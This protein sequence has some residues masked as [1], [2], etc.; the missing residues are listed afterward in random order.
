MDS[1]WMMR[2]ICSAE[3]SVSRMWP[4]PPQRGQGWGAFAQGGLQALAAHFHQAELADGA[5]LHAGA[6]L[7]QRVAQAVF[8]FAAV[9]ALP[10]R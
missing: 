5:E 10:C 8:H 4:E 9:L 3:L 1:S 7:A 6:V 2:R